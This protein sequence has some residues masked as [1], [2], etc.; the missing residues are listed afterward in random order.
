MRVLYEVLDPDKLDEATER[1]IVEKHGGRAVLAPYLRLNPTAA[2]W[3]LVHGIHDSPAGLRPLADKIAAEPGC[4]AYVFFY[5]D[6]GRYLDRTGDDLAR[7]LAELGAESKRDVRLVAHSMGGIVAR[8]AMNSLVNP[9]WL[10]SRSVSGDEP[11]RGAVEAEALGF[12]LE[13]P[14]ADRFSRLDLI[15]IDTPWHGF[16]D[17]T[18][19]VRNKMDREVSYVDLIASS[20]LLSVLCDVDLPGHFSVN[21][22]EADNL[23]GGVDEDKVVGLGELAPEALEA[24]CGY[25]KGDAAALA[26]QKRLHNQLKSLEDEADGPALLEALALEAKAGTLTRERFCELTHAAVPRLP[27]SH[28]SVLEHPE[29]WPEILKTFGRYR[30]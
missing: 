11:L 29:L 9:R 8:C 17:V 13:Q 2:P 7:A 24:L 1:A 20:T 22:I 12:R 21:L 14:R 4:Q 25:L 16:T 6:A 23:A 18:V 30:P 19:E 27:G 10:P 26:G 5:D 28:V 3:V 15:A